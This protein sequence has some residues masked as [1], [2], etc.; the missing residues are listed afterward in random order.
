MNF[1]LNEKFKY[2]NLPKLKFIFGAY[3]VKRF[4]YI[5]MLL[6]TGFALGIGYR[7]VK[8]EINAKRETKRRHISYATQPIMENK[9]FVVIILAKNDALFCEQNLLS[10]LSQEYENFRVIYIEN[11]STD[12]TAKKAYSFLQ[13]HDIDGKSLS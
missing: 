13:N 8:A 1:L 10:V 5:L 7:E 11:G 12:E 4:L 9:S 3:K 6:A 2:N